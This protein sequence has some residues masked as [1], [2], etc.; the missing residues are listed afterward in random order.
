MNIIILLTLQSWDYSQSYYDSSYYQGQDGYSQSYDGQSY[1]YNNQW[2]DTSYQQQ[3]QGSSTQSKLIDLQ[4]ILLV[5]S[6]SHI[7]VKYKINIHAYD[8][9]GSCAHSKMILGD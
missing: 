2:Y 3:Q 6:L 7:K 5:K 1:D 8:T 4:G 9:L